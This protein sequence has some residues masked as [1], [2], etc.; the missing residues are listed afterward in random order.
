MKDF[1]VQ[2]Y[3]ELLDALKDAGYRFLSY[4]QYCRELKTAN[5]EPRPQ[6]PEPKTVILRH[7]VDKKPFNSLRTAELEAAKGIRAS[8]YFRIVKESFM[9]EVIRKIAALRH[10]IGYHYEDMS[11]C[12]G[13]ARLA[14]Q[15]FERKLALLRT[16]YPVAT[17]CMH[18]APTSKFDG[19]ALWQVTDYRQYNIIGEPYFDTDFGHILYMTDTGGCWDGFKVSV[20]DKIP[21]HQDEWTRR[22]WVFHTTDELIAAIQS[23][24][25]PSLMLTTHPQRW[26]DNP[27]EW[28]KERMAQGLKNK[29]KRVLVWAKGS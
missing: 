4:E 1:T 19:R 27:R 12:K 16:F 21:G 23:G 20:R 15:H 24:Q 9:P 22:G 6:T 11:L 10:E 28:R 14:L 3:S 25:L 26:T 17:I 18:G 2:K 29:V 7:D 5:R 8:Y 13:D